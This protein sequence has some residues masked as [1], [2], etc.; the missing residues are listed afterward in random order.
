MM[1]LVMCTKECDNQCVLLTKKDPKHHALLL[2]PFRDNASMPDSPF[3]YAETDD[4][5]LDIRKNE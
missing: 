5:E 3:V 1:W 4:T 2:C